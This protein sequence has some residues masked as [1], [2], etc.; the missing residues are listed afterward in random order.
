MAEGGSELTKS[1]ELLAPTGPTP[2]VESMLSSYRIG[3]VGRID[4]DDEA[5]Q[6][7]AVGEDGR[8]EDKVKPGSKWKGCAGGICRMHSI[9]RPTYLDML[10]QQAYHLGSPSA[11]P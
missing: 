6:G 2:M 7:T 11:S 8:A 4:L 5:G 1:L 3:A 10:Q 9:N